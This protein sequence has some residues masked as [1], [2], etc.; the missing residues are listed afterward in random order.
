LILHL[1]FGLA[2][3]SL[4][5]LPGDPQAFC[6]LGDQQARK[7]TVAIGKAGFFQTIPDLL[8]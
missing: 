3:V 7:M 6:G 1:G 8:A 2:F 5:L 4:G